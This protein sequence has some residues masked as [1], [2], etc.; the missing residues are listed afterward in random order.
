MIAIGSFRD[1]Y[2]IRG[3]EPHGGERDAQ[4]TA[5]TRAVYDDSP[6]RRGAAMCEA[7]KFEQSVRPRSVRHDQPVGFVSIELGPRERDAHQFVV[8]ALSFANVRHFMSL[9]HGD[10]D[11]FE[12]SSP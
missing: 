10:S 3:A 1:L 5:F 7:G 12:W 8:S 4:T 2:L 11:S 6:L 9:C